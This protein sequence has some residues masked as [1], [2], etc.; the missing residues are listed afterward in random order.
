MQ[1]ASVADVMCRLAEALRIVDPGNQRLLKEAYRDN[2]RL[3]LKHAADLVPML[4]GKVVIT[5]DHG[6]ALGE[7][8]LFLHPLFRPYFPHRSWG[9]AVA[10]LR[11]VPWF[12]VR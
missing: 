3:V 4:E 8:G 2:L 11:I 12:E 10:E 5:S 7:H 1:A 6:E 9:L